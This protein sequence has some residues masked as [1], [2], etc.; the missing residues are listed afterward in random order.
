MLERETVI[1]QQIKRTGLLVMMVT[2]V[3]VVKLVKLV[4]VRVVLHL[5]VLVATLTVMLA[6]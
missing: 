6:Q 1:R 4:S 2:I 5:M 3:P